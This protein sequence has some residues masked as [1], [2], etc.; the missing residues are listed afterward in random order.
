M[1]HDLLPAILQTMLTIM[2][3]PSEGEEEEEEGAESQSPISLAA[4]VCSRRRLVGAEK[5]KVNQSIPSPFNQY[6]NTQ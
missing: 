5:V 1:R 2:A 4:Q 6:A 3:T